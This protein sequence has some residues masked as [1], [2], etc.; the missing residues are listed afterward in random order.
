MRFPMEPQPLQKEKKY[1]ITRILPSLKGF[2]VELC[3][4]RIS[5]TENIFYQKKNPNNQKKNILRYS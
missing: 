4:I 3:F 5:A 1:F 2:L